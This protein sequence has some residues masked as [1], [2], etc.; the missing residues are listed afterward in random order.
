MAKSLKSLEGILN[1]KLK[2]IKEDASETAKATAIAIVEQLALDTPVDTSQALSNWQVSLN[3]PVSSEI[4][5]YVGGEFGSSFG[6][7]FSATVNNA[8]SVLASKKPSQPIY[9]SNVLDYIADLNAG[10]SKQAPA[11][12]VESAILKGR[13]K[14]KNLKSKA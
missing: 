9:I 12:F 11:G 13:K 4:G 2:Q 14:A 10:S 3:N 8:R 5:P 1:K 6:A 7:S